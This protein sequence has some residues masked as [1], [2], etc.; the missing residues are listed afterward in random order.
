MKTAVRDAT[1]D[2]AAEI[3]A[4]EP[5]KSHARARLF[6]LMN[7]CEWRLVMRHNPH[8]ETTAEKEAFLRKRGADFQLGVALADTIALS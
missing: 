6:L 8:W 4:D 3:L 7:G 5:N 1:K 2:A